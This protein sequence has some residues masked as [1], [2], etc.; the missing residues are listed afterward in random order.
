MK[1]LKLLLAI[2]IAL[3][4]MAGCVP[5]AMANELP[6]LEQEGK[7]LT[8]GH[9]LELKSTSGFHINNPKLGSL[10]CWR[11][12]LEGQVG[13]NEARPKFPYF[14]I[15]EGGVQEIKTCQRAGAEFRVENIHLAEIVSTGPVSPKTNEAPASGFLSFDMLLGSVVCH[16]SGNAMNWSFV[17]GSSALTL[18]PSTMSVTPVAC[19]EKQS[20]WAAFSLSSEGKPVIVN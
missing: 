1:R 9:I 2:P 19:G 14:W 3:V 5:S 4:A 13:I 17:P 11:A 15:S 7:P 20:V 12:S 10:E 6:G 18:N 16:Y 8:P